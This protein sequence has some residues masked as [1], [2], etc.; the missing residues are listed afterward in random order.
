[1][2]GRHLF[3]PKK[4]N[5]FAHLLPVPTSG[6]SVEVRGVMLIPAAA[7]SL[8]KELLLLCCRCNVAPFGGLLPNLYDARPAR[9][10][11]AELASRRSSSSSDSFIP[12]RGFGDP[13]IC[14]KL[15][16]PGMSVMLPLE[17]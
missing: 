5:R 13:F 6:I 16:L 8:L 7:F 3:R 9:P 10:S 4:C 1:M 15:A 14:K 12:R 11:C 2:P 17:A